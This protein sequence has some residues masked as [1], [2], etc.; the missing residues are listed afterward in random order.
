MGEWAGIAAGTGTDIQS[1]FWGHSLLSL[2][3]GLIG[4]PGTLL[5]APGP[6]SSVLTPWLAPTGRRRDRHI[7]EALL[8]PPLHHGGPAS[9]RFTRS[10]LGSHRVR[11]TLLC[12]DRAGWAAVVAFFRASARL[13]RSISQSGSPSI[14][15]WLSFGMRH[16]SSVLTKFHSPLPP[17]TATLLTVPAWVL[18]Q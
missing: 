7:A 2:S 11:A 4:G 13:E 15:Q 12:S 3:D 17:L 6:W 5:P 10:L 9:E 18:S 16:H 1:G 14:V 8:C